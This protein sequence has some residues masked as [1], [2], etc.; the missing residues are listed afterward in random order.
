MPPRPAFQADIILAWVSS[1][2]PMTEE[3][4]RTRKKSLVSRRRNDDDDESVTHKFPIAKN[5]G[6]PSRN[7][8]QE[9][10]TFSVVIVVNNN[11]ITDR[12]TDRRKDVRTDGWTDGRTDGQTDTQT[13]IQTDTQ[14][15]TDRQSRS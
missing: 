7:G 2:Q 5:R 1:M 12:R 14:A 11:I 9:I 13:D 8:R 6:R 10:Y 4:P 3:K 15:D